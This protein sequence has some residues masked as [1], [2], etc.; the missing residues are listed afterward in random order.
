[1]MST[2]AMLLRSFLSLALVIALALLITKFLRGRNLNFGGAARPTKGQAAQ[3]IRIESKVSIAKGHQ[4]IAVNFDG[5][6]LL[7]GQGPAGSTILYRGTPEETE[8]ECSEID[9]T[10]SA[11]RGAEIIDLA[12]VSSPE[13]LILNQWGK[14]KFPT[15]TGAKR[16]ARMSPLFGL[17]GMLSE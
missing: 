13:D 5:R 12:D 3:S 6:N 4:L 11:A 17:K 2:I 16:A 7:V 14:G 1:M 15:M 10:E 9:L 8:T